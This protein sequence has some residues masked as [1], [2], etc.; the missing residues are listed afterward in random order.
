M[1]RYDM[2][3]HNPLNT[4]TCTRIIFVVYMYISVMDTMVE[5]VNE[6]TRIGFL[7][8]VCHNNVYHYIKAAL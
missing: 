8:D 5:K 2:S 3:S 6:F 7:R 4:C 1:T